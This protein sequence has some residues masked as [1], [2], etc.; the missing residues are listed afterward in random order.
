MHERAEAVAK[1]KA[2]QGRRASLQAQRVDA[3]AMRRQLQAAKR[4]T[5]LLRRQAVKRRISTI[6]GLE[7]G[8]AQPAPRGLQRDGGDDGD[9]AEGGAED[10]EA[11]EVGPRRRASTGSI[12]W[13]HA[14]GLG[15]GTLGTFEEEEEEEDGGTSGDVVAREEGDENADV[16]D[17]A[18]AR[19]RGRPRGSS[20]TR[21]RG[22]GNVTW[23]IFRQAS[24]LSGRDFETTTS[25]MRCVRSAPQPTPDAEAPSPA[26]Q[27]QEL[28]V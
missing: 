28:E 27:D 18:A 3:R 2:L 11:T 26:E 6:L 7:P 10:E 15:L 8:A 19:S 4:H 12:G 9:E 17:G 23:A 13:K 1:R 22:S 24:S 16:D 25:P 21:P 14:G 20:G 5:A